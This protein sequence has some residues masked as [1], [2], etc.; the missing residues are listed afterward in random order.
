MNGWMDGEW[1]GGRMDDMSGLDGWLVG[2]EWMFYG[3][4]GRRLGG[5][6]DTQVGG[7]ISGWEIE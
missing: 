6:V 4:M 3:W 1:R 2:G 5:R 7:L